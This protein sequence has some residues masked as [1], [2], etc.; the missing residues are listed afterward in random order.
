MAT[1]WIIVFIH[2]C[3]SWKQDK[4]SHFPPACTYSD[5]GNPV[6][7]E[8]NALRF[9]KQE[10]SLLQRKETTNKR[11]FKSQGVGKSRAMPPLLACLFHWVRVPISLHDADVWN[12]GHSYAIYSTSYHNEVTQTP[13]RAG[14]SWILRR[15]WAEKRQHYS[16]HGPYFHPTSA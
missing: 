6:N 13:P 7:L 4:M 12:I 11:K 9:L 14:T 10:N 16:L 1:T 2:N 8:K 3:T 5:A 15:I